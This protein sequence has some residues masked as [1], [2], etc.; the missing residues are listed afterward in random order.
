MNCVA[1]ESN[2]RKE[3]RFH[4]MWEYQEAEHDV[5][6]R[7]TALCSCDLELGATLDEA[8]GQYGK[9]GKLWLIK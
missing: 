8:A 9:W 4:L 6:M 3:L 5:K 7:R 2:I 1:Q